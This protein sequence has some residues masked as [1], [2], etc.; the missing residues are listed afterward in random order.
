VQV[1][2]EGLRGLGNAH[3]VALQATFG[4]GPIQESDGLRGRSA[5]VARMRRTELGRSRAAIPA[6]GLFNPEELTRSGRALAP[7]RFGAT[8]M[9]SLKRLQQIRN[10]YFAAVRCHAMDVTL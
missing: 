3:F 4:D 5:P 9:S 10:V 8:S 1:N 2:S 6:S 7:R